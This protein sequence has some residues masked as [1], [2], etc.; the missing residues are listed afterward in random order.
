MNTHNENR[1]YI[2]FFLNYLKPYYKI[3]SIILVYV[4]LDVIFYSF[5][6]LSF[7]L[8]IDEGFGKNDWSFLA[9]IIGLLVGGE[10]LVFSLGIG[11]WYLFSRLIANVLRDL[12]CQ[13]FK[14]LQ[15]L[16]LSDYQHEKTG[17]LIA[18]F[19]TDLEQIITAYRS[20]LSSI[21]YPVMNL[22]FYI[23]LL[24]YLNWKLALF[25][26]ALCPLVFIIPKKIAPYALRASYKVKLTESNFLSEVHENIVMHKCIDAFGLKNYAGQR[27]QNCTQRVADATI[28]S[29]FL[30]GLIEN[31]TNIGAS[32]IRMSVLSLGAFMVYKKII[33]VGTLISFHL[34]LGD[35]IGNFN[36]V[37]AF[38]PAFAQGVAGIRRLQNFL[39]S[40]DP[41]KN[42]TKQNEKKAITT[43]SQGITF[44][45]VCFS[46]TGKEKNLDA[47]SFT[48]PK[49]SSVALVGPSG[50]GKSTIINLL[51]HFYEPM[52]GKILI[53]GQDITTLSK[54]SLH[55]LIGFVPQEHILFRAT[56]G[57]NIQLG[58]LD[59][60][61]HEIE[62]AAKKA[63]IHD[64]IMGLPDRYDTALGEG[65]DGLSEGQKQRISIARAI[66]R[67]PAILLLDEIT[68]ALDPITEEA[69]NDTI[70]RLS[71]G[72]TCIMVTHHLN[73]NDH[74]DCVYVF[75][76]GSLVEQGT[77]AELLSHKN[78]YYRKLCS[79]EQ[80]FKP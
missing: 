54:E 24:N 32:L 11:S 31:S 75:D 16:S 37:S 9:L 44:D 6:P 68:S 5:V 67:R 3:V 53:D 46:Y 50:S 23:I 66:I 58:K 29:G 71:V 59:A 69:I 70:K 51:M 36:R 8:I 30:S 38:F 12:R 40:H 14:R 80:N 35:V 20:F 17:N 78:T 15:A 55:N 49:G 42:N 56:I 65:G 72:Y 73:S 43:F 13:I 41:A 26:L 19:S 52:T 62:S 64:F 60:T 1:P 2:K 57:E 61:Q 27:F 76:K 45:R 33:T 74:L 7:K 28:Q 34:L 63:E 10:V 4:L 25:S 39:T 47:I 48:I 18:H 21:I 77:H 22:L 79:G